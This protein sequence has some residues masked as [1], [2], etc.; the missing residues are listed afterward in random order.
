MRAKNHPKKGDILFVEP[1][2]DKDKIEA[3]RSLLR[4]K[5]SLRDLALFEVGLSS[6]LRASDILRIRLFDVE[7]LESEGSFLTRERKT[8]K[9]RR[10]AVSEKALG[11]LRAYRDERIQAG[12]EEKDFLFCGQRNPGKQ[13]MTV[14]WLGRLV[15]GW[16]R[17]AGVQGNYASHSLRKTGAFHR[18]E[19]GFDLP[20][21]CQWLNHSSERMTLRYIGASRGDVAEI[22]R[23]EI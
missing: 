18:R 16:C 6:A 12:A 5:K 19:A 14:S 22:S 23:F 11:V 20:S 4:A 13:P 1:I 10:V 2:R 9:I 15:A 3:I 21:L 8:Q 7:A 17:A